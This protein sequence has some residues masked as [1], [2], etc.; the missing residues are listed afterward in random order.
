M[1]LVQDSHQRDSRDHFR[2]RIRFDRLR[3]SWQ[4]DNRLSR[5]VYDKLYVVPNE[6]L[7]S[8]LFHLGINF[9]RFYI[10]IYYKKPLYCANHQPLGNFLITFTN[11]PFDTC[12]SSVRSRLSFW[13][14]KKG[15]IPISPG[16]W[17]A[18]T[19]YKFSLINVATLWL[20]CIQSDSCESEAFRWW[21]ISLSWKTF[22]VCETHFD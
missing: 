10:N 5:G 9:R 18:M 22:N 11:C 16:V 6:L 7:V 13:L 3:S 15:T 21:F 12:N 2:Y 4:I 19:R 8:N 14:G 17:S 20:S 1:L